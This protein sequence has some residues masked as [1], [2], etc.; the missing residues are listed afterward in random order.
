M[1]QRPTPSASGLPAYSERPR[2]FAPTQ[3]R[4]GC[5]VV[6]PL[7]GGRLGATGTA[8]VSSGPIRTVEML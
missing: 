2:A 6:G 4:R 5:R 3:A 1:H 7:L 8:G